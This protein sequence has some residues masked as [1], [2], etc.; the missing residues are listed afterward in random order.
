MPKMKQFG[1]APT[2]TGGTGEREG[3]SAGKD[4]SPRGTALLA[5]GSHRDEGLGVLRADLSS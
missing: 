3:R 1:A 5:R 4:P 2:R